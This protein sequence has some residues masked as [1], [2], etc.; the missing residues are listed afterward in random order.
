MSSIL[1][2]EFIKFH[3]LKESLPITFP[4]RPSILDKTNFIDIFTQKKIDEWEAEI[5]I[6]SC[7]NLL[8]FSN[9]LNETQKEKMK[10]WDTDKKI[11][12]QEGVQYYLNHYDTLANLNRDELLT[13]LLYYPRI[14]HINSILPLSEY[15]KFK[16]DLKLIIDCIKKD[17]LYDNLDIFKKPYIT[18][19]DC[20]HT[21]Y[22][23]VTKKEKLDLIFLNV[24]ELL[25]KKITKSQNEFNA[26]LETLSKK[27]N[28]PDLLK[29]QCK[30][31]LTHISLSALSFK[32][33][34]LS[35]TNLLNE[36]SS[37]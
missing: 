13:Q 9:S 35:Q 3:T 1:L 12:K 6:D 4:D 25:E 24:Y 17:Q 32:S 21:L 10:Q 30:Q 26:L 33:S 8:E 14:Y 28:L 18:L 23:N 29:K 5:K 11:L 37:S 16:K 15:V 19:I 27:T 31:F 22:D 36:K 2:D 7:I 20:P 34:D